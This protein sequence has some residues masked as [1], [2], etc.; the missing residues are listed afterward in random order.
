MSQELYRSQRFV[1]WQCYRTKKV[2]AGWWLRSRQNL[3]GQPSHGKNEGREQLRKGCCRACPKGI[4]QLA[5]FKILASLGV[6]NFPIEHPVV[7][8]TIVRIL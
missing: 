1:F 4:E 5:S 3:T 2:T 8:G 7:Q 6:H